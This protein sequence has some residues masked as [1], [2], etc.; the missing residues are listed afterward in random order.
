MHAIISQIINR[1]CHV[2]LSNRAVIKH[3]ISRLKRKYKTFASM[4]RRDRRAFMFACIEQ[5]KE[6]QDLYF[7]VTGGIR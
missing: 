7:Y 6:N 4:N 2:S 3:V 5:H 1:D